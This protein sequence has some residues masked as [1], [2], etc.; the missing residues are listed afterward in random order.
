MKN[1]RYLM[2]TPYYKEADYFLSRCIDS[3]RKQNV[4]CDHLFVADGFPSA[5]LDSQSIRHIKLDQNHNDFGKTPRG[6]GCLIGVAEEYDGIGL[7]DADNWLEPTHLEACLEAASSMPGGIGEC[8]YVV[9]RRYFRR[10]DET[11]MPI[12]EED[13]LIDTSSFFFLPGSYDALAFWATMPKA[14]SPI[15]DRVF[16]QVLRRRAYKAAYVPKPT[17][18]YHNL[19]ASSYKSLNE[20]VPKDAKPNADVTNGIVELGTRSPREIEILNRL[21]GF[22]LIAPQNIRNIESHQEKFISSNYK[23]TSRN[24]P[25]PCGS[26]RKFKHCCGKIA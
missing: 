20:P 9:A 18:N 21:A 7:L 3:V 26:G 23:N 12:A 14:V 8:D 24:A 5:F 22:S 10:P 19:W 2:V 25:C 17:V 11:I 15:C 16:T 6:V 1:Y 4:R 13:G